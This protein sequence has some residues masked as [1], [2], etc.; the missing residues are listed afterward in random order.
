[1]QGANSL[2][3]SPGL[4]K[5]SDKV[6]TSRRQHVV[7]VPAARQVALAAL[8]CFAQREKADNIARVRV[9][10]LLLSS[11]RRGPDAVCI[12]LLREV[13]DVSEDNVGRFTLPLVILTAANRTDVRRNAGVDDYVFFARVLV[14]RNATD[15]LEA[16]AVVDFIGNVTK[17]GVQRFQGECLLCNV[18]QTKV[19]C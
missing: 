5:S 14:Y 19:E 11:V 4:S 8:G 16:M 18:A 1:M 7:D 3:V 2:I 15:D 17:C 10:D 13:L 9:E 12:N 6:G